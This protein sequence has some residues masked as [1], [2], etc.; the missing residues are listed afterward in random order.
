MKAA[1]AVLKLDR[2]L[3]AIYLIALLGLL[4]FP[5][6]GP[7]FRL[8][9]IGA[10]KWMHVALFGGLAVL[11]RW[12]LSA[13]RHA[14]LVS[15]GAAFVV[16][17]A[18]EVAQSLVAY[19]SAEL[20]DLLAGLLGAMLGAVSMNRIV[21]SPVPKKSVGLLVAILG[22]MVSALFVL[23]DVIGVG[24]SNLFGTLQMAG[25]ALGALI[26]VGGVGVYVKGLRG[27]SR[28]S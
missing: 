26:T 27:E 18:T 21:S 2:L 19:R 9:S 6:E 13:N 23:A 20:W 12:N 17:V 14:V 10:D 15:V 1:T 16:A 3:L 24:K 4:M 11:L 25:T 7:N 28:P 22:V 5:I 8:L